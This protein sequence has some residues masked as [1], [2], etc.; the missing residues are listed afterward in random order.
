M[1]RKMATA[2]TMI[3]SVMW[4]DEPSQMVSPA[5]GFVD[6]GMMNGKSEKPTVRIT[7]AIDSDEAGHEARVV[8][9]VVIFATCL[10]GG[11]SQLYAVARYH[12]TVDLSGESPR[13]KRRVVRLETRGLGIGKHWPL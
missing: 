11:V 8:T 5:C 10:D 6:E 2:I 9:S 7:P 1:G 3:H 4:L 13:L 12:D